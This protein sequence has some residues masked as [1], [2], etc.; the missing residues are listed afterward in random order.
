MM[1]KSTQSG[2]I[3]FI[4]T[5]YSWSWCWCISGHSR[6]GKIVTNVKTNIAIHKTKA[7]IRNIHRKRIQ[8]GLI[9][10]F[11][12]SSLVIQVCELENTDS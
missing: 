5:F 2:F 8:K 12:N 10:Y 7:I 6:A 4:R 9:A 3:L 11:I 1:K